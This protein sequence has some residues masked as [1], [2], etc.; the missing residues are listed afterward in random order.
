M[1][2]VSRRMHNK[3]FTVDNQIA[4]L[5]GRN[6]GDEYFEADPDIAFS[7]LDVMIAGP[8]AKDVSV[9]F[10]KYW[11]SE[12]AYPATTLKGRPVTV[13]EIDQMR[14]YLDEFVA[15][16]TDSAYLNALRNS[17]LANDF[18]TR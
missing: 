13:A 7:D 8:A 11:N 6:I 5:G 1:G 15:K 3:S 4:I 9:A 18:E 16:Q 14:Q 2:V 10:D 12:L 17:T